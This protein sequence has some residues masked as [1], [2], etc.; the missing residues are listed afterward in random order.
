MEDKMNFNF[1]IQTQQLPVEIKETEKDYQISLEIPGSARDDIK[2][3]HEAGILTI[4]GEKK[5]PE[6]NRIWAERTGGQFSRTFQL[7]SDIKLDKIEANY[8]DGVLNVVIP[9]AE[10]AQPKTIEIK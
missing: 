10:Q 5:I 4:T 7:P 8:Q 3:W 2:M 6:T 1:L 9:K